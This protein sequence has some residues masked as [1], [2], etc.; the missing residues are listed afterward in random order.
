MNTIAAEETSRGWGGPLAMLAA[1]AIF[2]TFAT[3]LDAW[4]RRRD[5]SPGE[6]AGRGGVRV[7]S[8]V[9]TGFDT[10]DTD[11]DPGPDTGRERSGPGA[12]LR[13]FGRALWA[14]EDRELDDEDEE[15]PVDDGQGDEEEDEEG[16]ETI[17][18]TIRRLTEQGIPYAGIVRVLKREYRISESTAKRR[19]REVRARMPG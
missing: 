5:H 14:R 11:D 6:G 10:D 18:G 2:I 3:L 16:P 15:E 7:K 9:D 19:I 4:Q 13:D 17:E 8:Q 12:W 1:V